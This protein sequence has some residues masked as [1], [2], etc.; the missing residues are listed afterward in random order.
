MRADRDALKE[1]KVAWFL[2]R[3]GRLFHITASE[4]TFPCFRK[5]SCHAN[6]FI[7]E[8]LSLWEWTCEVLWKLLR[9]RIGKRPW[10]TFYI[11]TAKWLVHLSSEQQ[12]GSH[13]N[14]IDIH[15]EKHTRFIEQLHWRFLTFNHNFYTIVSIFRRIVTPSL[16]LE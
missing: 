9:R 13:S 6:K 3:M 5:R 15:L 1:V 4:A 14:K 11:V 16:N 7:S 12:P 10:I 8:P 2:A